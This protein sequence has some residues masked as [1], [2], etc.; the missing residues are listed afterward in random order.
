MSAPMPGGHRPDGPYSADDGW[1]P[2]APAGPE[3]PRRPQVAAGK[4]WGGGIMAALVAALASV[5]LMLLVRGVLDIAVFAPERDGTLAA[6]P[7][8]TLAAGAAVA[9]LLATAL[10]HLLLLAVPQPGRFFSCIVGLA[11]VCMMLLPFTTQAEWPPKIATAF[12]Y[13]VLGLVIGKLLAA[14]GRG[15]YLAGGG[16]RDYGWD[17]RWER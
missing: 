10:L 6:L 8:G 9:A 4:L 17:D 16:P 14:V 2:P 11:T 15:A 3:P 12:V 5:V 7:T 1:G 13:L